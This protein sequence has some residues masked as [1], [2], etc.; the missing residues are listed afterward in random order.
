MTETRFRE[1][2]GQFDD[3]LK[4]LAL[5][6]G[7]DGLVAHIAALLK[8]WGVE[9]TPDKVRAEPYYFDPRTGWDDWII[10]LDGYGV[11]GFTDGR[12]IDPISTPCK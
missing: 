6:D 5:V 1:H 11:V 10:T 3:S 8:P 12:P 4:T 2:R 9:V 7:F